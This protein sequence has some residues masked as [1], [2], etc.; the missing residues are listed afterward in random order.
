M[1]RIVFL[2]IDGVLVTERAI[3]QAKLSYY[4]VS[5]ISEV[6]SIEKHRIK[7]GLSKP[8][9]HGI[10]SPFDPEAINH[11]QSLANIGVEF[12]ISS[13][14]REEMSQDDLINHFHTKGLDIPIIGYTPV[15]NGDRVF[16]INEWIR[17]EGY[18]G[19]YC[20]VDDINLN[21]PNLVLT[22]PETGI[23]T[24]EYNQILEFSNSKI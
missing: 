20:I 5:N 3:L 15:E 12:V 11:L 9:F 1:E 19:K 4:G 17:S 2:D 23:T 22:N 7:N 6:E 16:E 13:T 21:C 14:W 24:V 8:S 18:S 10:N